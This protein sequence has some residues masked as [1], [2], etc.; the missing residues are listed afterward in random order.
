[1]KF[2]INEIFYSIQ[3]ES[4]FAGYPCLFVRF[5]G[6][7]LRCVYCDTSYAY[8]AGKLW[9]STELL[10][11]LRS[12][13]CNLV[14]LTGGEPL[15][16]ENILDLTN[17]L[18]DEGYTV[19]IETNGTRDI[20]PFSEQITFVLDIKCPASGYSGNFYMK[21]LEYIKPNDEIKFVI[22][23]MNDYSWAKD[24]ISR[25]GLAGKGN[26]IFSP[27][28]PVMDVRDL[29]QRMLSDNLNSVRLQLQ[30]HKCI[31]GADAKGV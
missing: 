9:S 3:G 6:C 27:A 28:I 8:D 20:S 29:A 10:D 1:M 24:F 5:S 7:N 21:N 31:W 25:Y 17:M 18:I 2:T 19:L 13:N 16:Q 15:I 22:S 12:Y 14:E 4:S 11:T 26:L 30:L 23:D